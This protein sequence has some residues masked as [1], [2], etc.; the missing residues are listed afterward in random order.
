MANGEWLLANI[1]ACLWLSVELQAQNT[2]VKIYFN[3]ILGIRIIPHLY[4][5]A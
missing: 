4:P 5:S 3:G 1:L 2:F